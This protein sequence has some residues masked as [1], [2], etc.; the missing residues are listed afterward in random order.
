[1]KKNTTVLSWLF[2]VLVFVSCH[3]GPRHTTIEMNDGRVSAK[4]KCAGDIHFTKDSSAVTSISPY[5]YIEYWG[6]DK[7]VVIESDEQ[8]KLSHELYRGETKIP[9]DSS[10]KVFLAAAVKEM[11]VLGLRSGNMQESN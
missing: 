6:N 5:G 1:M 4:I 8:G 11:I 10:G 2:T 3:N 9:L 7:H